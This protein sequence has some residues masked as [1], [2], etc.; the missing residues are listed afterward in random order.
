MRDELTDRLEGALQAESGQRQPDLAWVMQRGTRVRRLRLALMSTGVVT[1]VALAA[2]V[3]TAVLQGNDERIPLPAP[4]ASTTPDVQEPQPGEVVEDIPEVF[5]AQF[6]AMRAL[7][8]VG[9]M[10]LNGRGFLIDDQGEV[11]ETQDGWR[12]PFSAT[13]C[14]PSTC[15]PLSD[16]R[17]PE[18]GNPL[19]DTFVVVAL[20][21]GRWEVVGTEGNMSQEDHEALLGFS[22]PQMREPSHW[23]AHGVVTTGPDEGFSVQM[24]PVWVGPIPTAAPGSVCSVQPLDAEGHEVGSASLF[25]QEAPRDEL[26]RAGSVHGRG[27][28]APKS[29]VDARVDCRQYVGRGWELASEPEKTIEGRDIVGLSAELIWR[30]EEGFTTAAVC[31]GTLLD[32]DQ[33]VVFEGSGRVE[34]LWRESELK[35]Y[36]YEVTA[37]ISFG[38]KRFSGV[39]DHQVGEFDC[40]SR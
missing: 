27:I 2:V 11:V 10:T 22:L 28:S 30:G 3:G 40:E 37:S 24:L 8:A 32:E 9:L 39:E 29:A 34:P 20:E 36:P 21:D 19:S 13:E 15:R 23:E 1:V 16:E 14:D 33:E 17:D 35:Q 38:G 7:D 4:A 5:Q 12:V 6:F 31:H 26:D 18:S 25:F